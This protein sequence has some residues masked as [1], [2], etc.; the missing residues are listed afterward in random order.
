MLR[1]SSH[2]H[3]STHDTDA[4]LFAARITPHRSMGRQGFRLTMTLICL[5]SAIS[6]VPLLLAGAWFAA[7]LFGLG[8]GALALALRVHAGQ[9][10]SH[11]E[12]RLSRTELTLRRVSHGSEWREWHFNPLWTLLEQTSQ[13]E[14]SQAEAGM[15]RLTLSSRGQRV[16]V[17]DAL[18]PIERQSLGAALEAALNEARRQ[19]GRS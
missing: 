13:A 11:E 1:P 16:T 7:A 9:A 5:A 2:A 3:Q 19:T 15:E 6:A 17:G 8:I 12:L 18:S 10:E 14:T 4:P